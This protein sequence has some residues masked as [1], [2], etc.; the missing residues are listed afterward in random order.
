MWHTSYIYDGVAQPIWQRDIKIEESVRVISGASWRRT[1]HFKE[2][3]KDEQYEQTSQ[4]TECMLEHS[5]KVSPATTE[6]LFREM[7]FCEFRYRKQR[8]KKDKCLV[9]K[10]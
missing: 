2:V 8:G 1:D 4:N 9:W 7:V 3:E 5:R 6:T 10:A